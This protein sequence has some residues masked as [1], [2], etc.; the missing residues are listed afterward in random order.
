MPLQGPLVD[1]LN[2][3]LKTTENFES[4]IETRINFE[5]RNYMIKNVVL[6]PG[7][8]PVQFHIRK[9]V[10]KKCKFE[11]PHPQPNAQRINKPNFVNNSSSLKS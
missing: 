6:F 2:T 3:P 8:W 5:I 4:A 11:T 10:Y 7:D 1:F 9:A